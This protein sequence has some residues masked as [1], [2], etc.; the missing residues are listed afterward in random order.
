MGWPFF[1]YD[2]PCWADSV[3]LRPLIFFSFIF[4]MTNV[5]ASAK[6]LPLPPC[7]CAHYVFSMPI[8]FFLELLV[9]S[10]TCIN[11]L[12]AMISMTSLN[13]TQ[14]FIAYVLVVV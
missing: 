8:A 7:Y 2:C 14:L 9:L 12:G 4:R 10:V 13:I 1:V 5:H 6:F 11:H 3:F